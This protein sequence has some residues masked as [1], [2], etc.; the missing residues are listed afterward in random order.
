MGD[1]GW[2]YQGAEVTSTEED[3]NKS[4]PGTIVGEGGEDVGERPPTD[5]AEI[6][7]VITQ[8]ARREDR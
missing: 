4:N 5:V 7:R 8:L 3:S 1:E 6:R 2:Y